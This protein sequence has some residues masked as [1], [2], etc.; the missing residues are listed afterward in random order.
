MGSKRTE[1]ET[2]IFSLLMIRLQSRKSKRCA[3]TAVLDPHL[4]A[5][6]TPGTG[7]FGIFRLIDQSEMKGTVHSNSMTRN[8]IRL[9][10]MLNRRPAIG[11][12]VFAIAL[13]SFCTGS[14][15]SAW[16]NAFD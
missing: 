1:V 4:T 3:V 11:W 7:L 5:H 16:V 10:V 8:G 9:T 12:F 6:L 2:F 14:L 15:A 13:L